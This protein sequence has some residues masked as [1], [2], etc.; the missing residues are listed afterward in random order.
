VGF[1][2]RVGHEEVDAFSFHVRDAVSDAKLSARAGEPLLA[3]FQGSLAGTT[4]DQIFEDPRMVIGELRGDLRAEV[5]LERPTRSKVSGA[6]R[7]TAIPV[8]LDLPVPITIERFSAQARGDALFL[9]SATLTSGDDRVELSGDI[10]RSPNGYEVDV[11]V[12]GDSVTLPE[13]LFARKD[14][15]KPTDKRRP[16]GRWWKVFKIPVHGRIGVDLGRLRAPRVEIAPLKATGRHANRRIDLH[17]EHAALCSI[18]MTGDVTAQPKD[19]AVQATLTAR[20]APL[21]QSIHC[22][23]DRRVQATGT[24][25]LDASVSTRGRTS[26]LRNNL[27]G[28]F[29]L[30]ARDGR[31]QKADTL[32]R[33]LAFV[34]LTEVM[35]G[36]IENPG[37]AGMAYSSF[38]SNGAIEGTIV[39]VTES[40]LD[41]DR[42]TLAF[43]G[44]FDYVDKS[45]RANVLVAP[46]KAVTAIFRRIPILSQIFGG[47]L[48]A[49]PVQVSGTLDNLVILPL[50]P[51]AVAQ[52]MISIVGNTL[53]LPFELFSAVPSSATPP[54]ASKAP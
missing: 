33:V 45:I 10:E 23:S 39:R 13:S 14:E 35:R 53:K 7:G 51:Q 8:A 37:A 9:E 2:V 41:A 11:D 42:V 48:I 32:T 26:Q 43:T 29:T 21:A 54:P 15:E 19:I 20:N 36:Q 52:R 18:S 49:I 38:T 6:L 24:F 50:S 4:V 17:V 12:R 28:T 47:K 30:S 3:S 22:L 31:I 46:I 34:N 44:H 25:D 27:R 1:A 40:V 16:L 5:D